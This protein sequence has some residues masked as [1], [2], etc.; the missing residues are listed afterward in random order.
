MP[1]SVPSGPLGSAYSF[2]DGLV[3]DVLAVSLTAVNLLRP[4]YGPDGTEL[5]DFA[6]EYLNPA[7][8]YIT[9]LPE[10]PNVTARARFPNLFTNGVFDFYRRVFETGEAGRYD[11]PYQ[12]DGFDHYCHVAARRS[13]EL[14]VVN[15]TDPADNDHSPVELAW[16]QNHADQRAAR[17]EAEDQRQARERAEFAQIFAH[18]PAAICIQRGPKHRYEYVNAAYQAF[19]PDRQLLGRPVAEALPETV[20]SGVVT[21]LDHVY[22]TGQT[23]YGYEL[24]LLMAQ[25]QG[26]PK[27]MYFTF[28]YQAYR[29]NGQ[30]VGISTF[31]YD[32]AEQ[33]QARQQREVEQRQLQDLFMQA[34]APIAILTGPDLVYQLV[35]PAYQ[36]IFPGR[37]LLGKSLATALPELANSPI[38]DL[39]RRV[40]ETG[41]T[42]VA[43]EMRL[44]LARTEG[45]SV[46]ELYFTFTYQARRTAQQVVDGI[47]VFVYEVTDQVRARQQSEQREAS[48]RTIADAAPTMLWVTD[49]A[50]Q[51]TYVNAQ[52]YQYTGQTQAEA[53]GLGWTSAVH[54]AD[55][56]AASQAFLTATDQRRRF[57]IRCRLRRHDGVYRWATDTGLPRF[58]ETGEYAGLV[59]TVIDVHEQQLA[60][61]EL[62]ASNQQ[63]TRTNVD[64]DNFIY[65]ASH[66]LRV[67]IANIEGLLNLLR[68]QLPADVAQAPSV[69]AILTRMLTSVERFTRTIGHLT[70]VSKLRK[71][72]TPPAAAISLAAV[73]EDVRLDLA[74][75][76]EA[77]HAQL[78]VGVADFPPVLCSEKNLRSVIYNLLSNAVK[79][80]HPDRRPHIDVQA[81]VS[82][83]YTVLEVHDNG[84]GLGPTHLPKLFDM[85]QRFH[86]HIE[87]TGIGLYMVKRMVENAGGRIEV[88]SQLGAGT[89]FFVR[90]PHVIP[91]T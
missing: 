36:R 64:L 58:T 30:L 25:P 56:E 14:L 72:H 88:H 29:E 80:R 7:A 37:E 44:L 73:V 19:F 49:P 70:E 86:P 47:L 67:P 10:Q 9:D 12:A 21:L 23:Y 39:L 34:P 33:V 57:H 27:Q 60:E 90:L 15:F 24:P 38:P 11:F 1:T 28:T 41:E 13:G 75:L 52:W 16:R 3:L 71:E 31:A 54:P 32:V 89:T 82:A 78:T 76:F 17:A 8:Q 66:D 45:A 46:E 4:L 22:E 91:T 63:L 5:V 51:C 26:P 50:G 6:V 85:F 40:Y 61:D 62:L 2:P 69:A 42:H 83:G 81:H 65:T 48:F 87:G 53:L 74:P 68:K 77:A 35:N 59:G 43:Q 79:Y 20:D 84:L 18:T 55:V